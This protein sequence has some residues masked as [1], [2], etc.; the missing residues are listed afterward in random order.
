MYTLRIETANDEFIRYLSQ[1]A[2]P[3]GSNF[4]KFETRTAACKTISRFMF[5]NLREISINHFIESGTLQ[6]NHKQD[7]L[8][9]ISSN[10]IINLLHSIQNKLTAYLCNQ[11]TLHFEG[12]HVF[13]LKDEKLK[14]SSIISN[15]LEDFYAMDQSV[16]NLTSLQEILRTNESIEHELH[17]IIENDKRLVLRNS[18]TVL[19]QDVANNED[20]IL[21]HLIIRSP[22]LVKVHQTY[23]T[24][25]KEGEILLKQLFEDKVEFTN[26]KFISSSD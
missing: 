14:T 1:E 8:L 24:L 20:L 19:I 13:R 7:F 10:D 5:Y 4:F 6:K 21:S 22:K 23:G 17:I 12:F 25:T 15:A 3:N 26:D 16:E 2:T 11:N 9:Y 18:Q